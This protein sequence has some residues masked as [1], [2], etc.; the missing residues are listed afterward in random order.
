MDPLVRHEGP[1][2]IIDVWRAMFESL[3]GSRAILSP[4]GTVLLEHQLFPHRT[5]GQFVGSKIWE[6]VP[7]EHRET[8]QASVAEAATGS[9][10]EDEAEIPTPD[11][12]TRWFD[13]TIRPIWW[14]GVVR[15]L[16]VMGRDIT[17]QTQVRTAHRE[18]EEKYRTLFQT[19]AQGVVYQD[20][21]GRI[22]SANP[23][24]ERIL[25][26][27]VGEMLERD[28]EDP[29]WAAIH[30]DGSEYPGEEHPAMVALATGRE[31][32]DVIMA[33]F[34][35]QRGEH[36]WINISA[37]PQFRPG[38]DGPHRV[39]ASF[40]DITD[41]K[42]TED[43]LRESQARLEATIENLP[44][45][46][47]ALDVDG[48]YILQNSIC[49]AHW[50]D[51]IGLR[52]E[53]VAPT[54]EVRELWL[55]NNRRA[56]SGETIKEEVEYS[57]GG[58]AGAYQNIIT[59]IREQGR[60]SGILGV[61]VDVTSRHRAEESLRTAEREKGTILDSLVEHVIHHDRDMRIIW[62]NR[63]AC[64]SVGLS[65]EEVKGR[66]C[67]ELWAKRTGLCPDCPV[68]KSRK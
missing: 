32:R 48:R 14:D 10:A 9:V 67:Y 23:A 24:A 29:K 54:D 66:F 63:A 45:D 60:V 68:V 35:P 28:S 37:V 15:A 56:F 47:F 34:N 64:E 55:G 12:E 44:F 50:G 36:R 25:G 26:I 57:I 31:V 59:P 11:G 46:F 13:F 39:Y 17:E 38:E 51:L 49:R 58:E 8:V 6:H 30:E 53:D 22:V 18:S 42:R 20:A 1:E 19:M 33:V 27:S 5:E 7:A 52:P 21:Q 61:N 41:R 16:L 4:D 3:P 65:R 62:A 40:T 43:A 2:E